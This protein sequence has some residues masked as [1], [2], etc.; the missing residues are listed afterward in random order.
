M[1]TFGL[2]VPVSSPAVWFPSFVGLSPTLVHPYL[3]LHHNVSFV[4][5]L[6]NFVHVR[7]NRHQ[8]FVWNIQMPGR[9]PGEAWSVGLRYF[10]GLL[11]T[12]FPLPPLSRELL[13]CQTGEVK[14]F[15]VHRYRKFLWRISF[16]S[17]LAH[18][19]LMLQSIVFYSVYTDQPQNTGFSI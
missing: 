19:I 16:L 11:F 1:E 12:Q 5:K 9:I 18:L 8:Y 3:D 17:F 14:E 6:I 2:W 7:G 15:R 10:P 13:Q 4:Q